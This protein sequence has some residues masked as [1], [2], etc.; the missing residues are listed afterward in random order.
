MDCRSFRKKHLAYL[1]DTMPAVEMAAMR[2]HLVAC[3][4]CA[5]HDTAIRRSLL[6]VRN[7]PTIRPS[8]DFGARL[9]ARLAEERRLPVAPPFRGPGLR[10]FLATAASIVGI[11][12][13]TLEAFSRFETPVVEMRLA[14][15]EPATVMSAGSSHAAGGIGASGADAGEPLADA[16]LMASASAGVPVW[17]A[18]MLAHEAPMQFA[19]VQFRRASADE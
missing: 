7:M 13:L 14:V 4:D 10:A 1:D 9:R 12:L 2:H 15:V 6:V 16:M 18:L 17:P 3:E 19:R 8:A 5:R 11:G